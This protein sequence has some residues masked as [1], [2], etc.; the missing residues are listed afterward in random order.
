MIRLALN[1]NNTEK[2]TT[3]TAEI[4]LYDNSILVVRFIE[5]IGDID[6]QEAKAQFDAGFKLTG[7]KKIPVLVDVRP[8]FHSLTKEAK[9]FAAKND[10]K[11]AEAILVNSLHQRLIGTF[12]LKLVSSFSSH[13]TKIFNNE[14]EALKWLNSFV[15]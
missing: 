10:M 14:N 6:L 1:H 3:K 2:I 13:P 12:F 4:F 7:G 9:E 11:T 5:G 8:S 15:K